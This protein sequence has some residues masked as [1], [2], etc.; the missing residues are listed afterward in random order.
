[1]CRILLG[2]FHTGGQPLVNTVKGVI[3]FI[4]HAYLYNIHFRPGN[5]YL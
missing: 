5:M 4:L 3:E 2:M 1:M